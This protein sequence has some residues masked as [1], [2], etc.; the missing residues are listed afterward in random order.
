LRDVLSDPH[1]GSFGVIAI[2][3]QLLAKLVLLRD[4]DAVFWLVPLPWRRGS[5]L[6][7]GH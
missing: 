3:L 2:A 7:S 5:G 1:V 6:W 4:L